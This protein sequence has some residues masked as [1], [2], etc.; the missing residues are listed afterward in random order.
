RPVVAGACVPAAADRGAQRQRG[1]IRPT[2]LL[3]ST[4]TFFGGQLARGIDL[5]LEPGHEGSA[6]RSGVGTPRG[7]LLVRGDAG[8]KAALLRGEGHQISPLPP[9][10]GQVVWPARRSRGST[11]TV[12]VPPQ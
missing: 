10:F 5:V 1:E 6:G 9:H 2:G 3:G 11:G 4:P 12:P 8:A 7:V